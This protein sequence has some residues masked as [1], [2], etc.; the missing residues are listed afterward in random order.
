MSPYA[1]VYNNPVMYIDMWGLEGE[2][3]NPP[4]D[5]KQGDKYSYKNDKGNS[6]NYTYEKGVGWV[7]EGYSGDIK[8]V[9]ITAKRPSWISRQAKAFK[10][11]KSNLEITSTMTKEWDQGK[12]PVNRTFNNDVVANAM[13]DAWR[14]NE[15]RD[16][17]YDKYK[18]ESNLTGASVTGYRGDFGIEGL[19]KA[20]LDPVEQ[21]VGGYRV[22]IKV[23]PGSMLQFTITN[24]TSVK[25]ALYGKGKEW[26]RSE[27]SLN[28]NTYQTYIFTEPIRR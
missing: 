1:Y 6:S 19:F 14:V 4:K 2:K 3:P 27:F 20:G 10:N 28:G 12:G 5:A 23:I 8:G 18:D 26:E 22:N 17:F 24:K 21:F 7:G 15:A 25:S 16:F 13:R 11:W 9:T